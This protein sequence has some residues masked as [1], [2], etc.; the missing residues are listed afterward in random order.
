MLAACFGGDA[1][2]VCRPDLHG[3]SSTLK[4]RELAVVMPVAEL[5]LEPR[6]CSSRGS[7]ACQ[8]R[9]GGSAA[10]SARCAKRHATARR[11]EAPLPACH[12]R[13]VALALLRDR[14]LRSPIVCR[15]RSSPKAPEISI[16]RVICPTAPRCR[17]SRPRRADRRL[18]RGESEGSNIT[19]ER[20]PSLLILQW[21]ALLPL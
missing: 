12:C 1:Q 4:P 3:E 5:E 9:A 14:G 16:D 21:N 15:G 8:G 19:R 2:S 17:H 11:F 7:V 18:H 20:P 13:S 6:S 10:P